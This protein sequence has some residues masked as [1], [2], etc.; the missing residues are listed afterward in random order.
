MNQVRSRQPRRTVPWHPAKRAPQETEGIA[1]RK[2]RRG[3]TAGGFLI[4]LG[5]LSGDQKEEFLDA[6]WRVY[7]AHIKEKLFAKIGIES[8]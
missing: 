8:G 1:A 2:S 7:D 5:F 6:K 4:P 3:P